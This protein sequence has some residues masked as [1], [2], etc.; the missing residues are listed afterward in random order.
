MTNK[1]TKPAAISSKIRTGLLAAGGL[2][3]GLIIGQAG[4]GDATQTASAPAVTVT[5]TVPGPP[6]TVEVAGPGTTVTVPGPATTVT[7][8]APAAAP[9][10]A[11]AGSTCDA[12]REAILTGSKADITKAFKALIADKGAP[13]T[14]REYARY[15]LGRDAGDK[16]M[17]EMDVGLIQMACS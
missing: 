1:E 12:A 10:A 3:L 8:T 13:A 5:Q 4:G 6:K 11:P 14:A 17:Q 15:Y 9:E 16:Q 2:V 7:V